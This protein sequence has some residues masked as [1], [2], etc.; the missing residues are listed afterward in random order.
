MSVPEAQLLAALAEKFLAGTATAAEQ[1]QLH[2]LYDKWKDDEQIVVS[3]TEQTEILRLEILQAIKERIKGPGSITPFYKRKFWRLIAAASILVVMGVLLFYFIQPASSK[4][5]FASKDTIPPSSQLP[6]VPGKDRATLTFS[7]GTVIDLDSSGAGMLAQQGNTSII[8][9]DGKLIYDAGQTGATE[10]IYN[11][12]S[13]ARGGQYRLVLPDGTK[14]WLNATSALK[15]P[16]AF[17]G[18]SR[19]V[20]LTGEA[21]FEVTK[22]P[23]RPFKVIIPPLPGGL[24]GSEVKVLGTH[25]N[26][27]A[28]RE[29]Q[30]IKT[31]LLEGSVKVTQNAASVIIK[32][33]EQVSAFQSSQLSQPVPVPIEEVM[34]WKNGQFVFNDATIESI[35]R[36]AARWYDLEVVYE[37]KISKHFVA[38]IPRSVPLSELLKLLELT[39]QVH[40]KVQGKKIIV[41]Q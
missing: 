35:M 9:K 18:N 8:S 20:E 2:Q 4:K 38:N 27:M 5:A 10:I 29:E 12:I 33:G 28:Y 37:A 3:A 1:E 30:A 15:F 36:Q 21:Y 17:T 7:N 11:T 34:A 41:I 26:I 22:N 13:T 16:V 14:V 24:G 6:V 31:T 32:P 19:T 40:F 39:D 25:F 23:A